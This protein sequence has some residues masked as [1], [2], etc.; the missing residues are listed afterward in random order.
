[1]ST[2]ELMKKVSKNIKNKLFLII[3]SVQTIIMGFLFIIQVLRIYVGNEGKFTREIC[4][5][6]II[7]ILPAIILWILLIIAS[8]IY[9]YIKGNPKE[10]IA[11]L[12][13]IN[14]LTNLENICPKQSQLDESLDSA[15]LESLDSE[16]RLLNRE[17]KNRKIAFIATLVIII[18]SSVM[19][20]L[21]L[22]NPSH[23][24]ST[25]DVTKQI[26][27]MSIYLLPWVILSFGSLIAYSIY[28]E[29]SSK[30]SIE[31]IKKIITISKQKQAKAIKQENKTRAKKVI[32]LAVLVIAIGLIVVGLLNDGDKSVLQKAI[33]ICNECI[34]LG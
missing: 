2:N 21:Y 6:Y 5:D 12:S 24:D 25:G 8:F 18:I 4:K 9:Y 11:K 10:K 1:M 32:Q 17:K 19:G 3:T 34:G 20:L 7:Q 22:V 31:S 23:F 15:S 14:K 28:E 30:K 33:T 29:Y 13:N 27:S 26:G 16:Y